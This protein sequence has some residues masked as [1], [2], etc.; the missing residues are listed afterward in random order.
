MVYYNYTLGGGCMEKTEKKIVQRKIFED[1][2]V[3]ITDK[4]YDKKLW[5]E[6]LVYEDGTLGYKVC[7]QITKRSPNQ[8]SVS[9]GNIS[10]SRH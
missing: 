1:V 8:K 5:L 2:I 10:H 4:I 7:K 9:V 3:R 6:E